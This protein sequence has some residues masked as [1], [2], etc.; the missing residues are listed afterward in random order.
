MSDVMGVDSKNLTQDILA[1][2]P[3]KDQTNAFYSLVQ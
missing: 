1:A 3:N 2:A